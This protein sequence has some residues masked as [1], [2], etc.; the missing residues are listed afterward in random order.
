MDYEDFKLVYIEVEVMEKEFSGVQNDTVI[1]LTAAEQIK[2]IY[3]DMSIEHKYLV[4]IAR[5][6]AEGNVIPFYE[7]NCGIAYSLTDMTKDCLINVVDGMVEITDKGSEV[8]T[9]LENIY[10]DFLATDWIG[11]CQLYC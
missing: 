10:Y 11:E 1:E 8:V 5:E 2:K 6:L 9:L 4:R 3:P 7:L